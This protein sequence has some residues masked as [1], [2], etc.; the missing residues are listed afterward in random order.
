[1]MT[2]SRP[3]AWTVAG[4]MVVIIVPRLLS[5]PPATVATA[6]GG[7]ETIAPEFV[8]LNGR[9]LSDAITGRAGYLLGVFRQQGDAL[10]AA[11]A[12]QLDLTQRVDATQSRLGVFGG[13][14]VAFAE[15]SNQ[16]AELLAT[17]LVIYW[18]TYPQASE[19]VVSVPLNRPIEITGEGG[20]D[21]W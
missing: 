1:M 21:G 3:L 20:G 4:V 8:P 2:I 6:T 16:Y 5:S 11:E 13:E 9:L 19:P 7:T 15:L 10:M 17:E 14:A 12:Y 18:L